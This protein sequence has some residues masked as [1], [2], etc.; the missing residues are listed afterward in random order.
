MVLLNLRFLTKLDVNIDEFI[1]LSNFT[2]KQRLIINR[3]VA[4]FLNVV[5]VVILIVIFIVYL[6]ASDLNTYLGLIVVVSVIA[7][8]NTLLFFLLL[9]SNYS[10]RYLKQPTISGCKLNESYYY[11]YCEICKSFKLNRTH[12]SKKL[13]CCVYKFDHF[14]KWLGIAINYGNY[15]LFLQYVTLCLIECVI[16]FVISLYRLVLMQKWLGLSIMYLAITALLILCLASLLAIHLKLISDNQT[17]V[18]FLNYRWLKKNDKQSGI[19]YSPILQLNGELEYIDIKDCNTIYTRRGL[20][21][22]FSDAL[23]PMNLLL[24]LPTFN[25]FETLDLEVSD[26]I[27][28]KYKFI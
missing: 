25:S 9:Y 24:F 20:L 23:G 3:I 15:K 13:N 5:L 12:H 26:K 6:L 1:P 2:P 18:E 8:Y 17:T 4:F 16:I 10:D 7:W 22:N 27:K 11:P 28:E 21:S 19:V 14:C